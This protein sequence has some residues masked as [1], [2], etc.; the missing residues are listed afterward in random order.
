MK[1]KSLFNDLS[2]DLLLE[3]FDYLDVFDLFQA[4]FNLNQRF[5]RLIADEHNYF[6][7]NMISIGNQQFL[8]YK[9]LILPKIGAYIRYLSISDQMNY[10]QILL[11]SIS[12][13][14]LISIRLYDVQLSELLSIL[15]Q[16]NL[17][18]LFIQTKSIQNEKHLDNLFRILFEQQSNLRA[19]ECQLFTQLFFQN[20]QIKFSQLKQIV[21]NCD[22]YSSDFIVLISQLPNL[23]QISARIND[24]NRDFM[25]KD[26][27][28]YQ[29]N[30][31]I[32]S[33]SLHIENIDYDR[34]VFVF[35]FVENVRS[36]ELNGRIDFEI[37]KI[38]ELEKTFTSF[39]CN[40]EHLI[41]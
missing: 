41:K 3:I 28:H 33:I 37:D 36:V 9:N 29:S 8:F 15:E 25:D 23:R 26:I 39:R 18:Y 14:N 4:F 31:S 19:I 7:A 13:R 1:R 32:R 30:Q 35:S 2:N 12:F 17:K 34:L 22:C 5:N 40:L 10:L 38:F 21:L 20:Y 6:Q 16:S 24:L 11:R 27:D